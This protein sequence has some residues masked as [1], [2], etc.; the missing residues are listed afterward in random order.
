MASQTATILVTG[1]VVVDW[2][3]VDAHAHEDE[4][5]DL[6]WFVASGNQVHAAALPGGAGRAA[7]IMAAAVAA[8]PAD[9]PVIEVIGPALPPEVLV[10]PLDTRVTRSFSLV[11]RFPFSVDDR[12]HRVWRLGRVW[13]LAPAVSPDPFLPDLG[14]RTVDVLAI[15]DVGL[16]YRGAPETW[17]PAD[18]GLPR[19]VVLSTM[20]PFS[21]NDLLDDL[22]RRAADRLT[23]VVPVVELRKTGSQIGYPLSWERTAEE[24]ESAVR[25]HALGRA[26][27][28]VVQLELSGAVVVDRDGPTTLVFDPSASEGSWRLR[29][30][31]TMVGYQLCYLAAL[32]PAFAAGGVVDVPEAVRRAVAASRALHRQGLGLIE[33]PGGASLD[34]PAE[35]VGR[36]LSEDP[37]EIIATFHPRA[38]GER[39]I[40]A[41]A[42]GGV[43][44][45]ATAEQLAIG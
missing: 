32:A 5:L 17:Y 2:S 28:V 36:A 21:G 3:F 37:A 20:A 14:D 24:V 31:G 41:G 23:I 40:I 4:I 25:A 6:T 18:R 33:E 35:A 29:H 9:G 26:A 7:Q 11:T 19:H 8:L 22:L 12:T 38:D 10:S 27:R 30:P 45:L 15:Q 16:G 13:G 39:S 44:P 42:L 1:D 34:Y 43:S